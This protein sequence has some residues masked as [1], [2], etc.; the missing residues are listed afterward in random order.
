[1]NKSDTS[2]GKMP[3]QTL[4]KENSNT[5]QSI[6]D[7][8]LELLTEIRN[9]YSSNWFNRVYLCYEDVPHLPNNSLPIK[10]FNCYKYN[11]PESV[12][13]VNILK[14]LKNNNITK[15]IEHIFK[16]YRVKIFYD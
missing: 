16:K 3:E 14:F 7:I 11:S 4:T 6:F 5:R 13:I 15:N 8:E 10:G 12:Y 1:M 9:K 2:C